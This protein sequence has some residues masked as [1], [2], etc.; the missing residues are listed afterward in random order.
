MEEVFTPTIEPEIAADSVEVEGLGT[1]NVL[2]VHD[3]GDLTVFCGGKK[4]IVTAEGDIFESWKKPESRID[5][6]SEV[7]DE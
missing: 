6:I 7:E 3:D 2:K 1:C 4:F 5:E